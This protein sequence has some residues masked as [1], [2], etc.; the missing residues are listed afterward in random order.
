M[1]KGKGDLSGLSALNR[2]TMFPIGCTINVSLFIGTA[3]NV[4]LPAY[5]PASSLERAAAWKAWPWRWKGCLPVSLLLTTIS[6]MSLCCRT[7]GLE[8][9]P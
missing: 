5:L 1:A 2:R 9:R 8:L 6:I 3:A 7:W 4:S